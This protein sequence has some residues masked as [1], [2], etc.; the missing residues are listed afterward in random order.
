MKLPQTI[1]ELE[2]LLASPIT[3]PDNFN[4]DASSVLTR[5]SFPI[6]DIARA[7]T[8]NSLIRKIPTSHGS[9]KFSSQEQ[10]VEALNIL[11][12]IPLG[13][14][15]I[16]RARE[17]FP[18]NEQS[19]LKSIRA[20]YFEQLHS[21]PDLARRDSTF[22]L[23]DD[24]YSKGLP[25]PLFDATGKLKSGQYFEKF[26]PSLVESVMQAEELRGE[27][28]SQSSLLTTLLFELFK[29]TQ[30]H[31]LFDARNQGIVGSVRLISCRFYDL[32]DLVVPS[33]KDS[34]V[35]LEPHIAFVK[36]LQKTG[37]SMREQ[38]KKHYQGIL[39]FSVMD[40]GP[41]FVGSWLRRPVTVDEDISTEYQAVLSCLRAGHSTARNPNR[42]L[43]L[44][45]VLRALRKLNGFIRIRT[46]RISVYR[47]FNL[48]KD[49]MKD[50]VDAVLHD[51][52]KGL[53]S[54]ASVFGETT[55]AAVS[56][57]VP[58]EV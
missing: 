24:E 50:P 4:L 33:Q 6:E 17:W 32:N 53:S 7:Q 22:L 44:T 51:W 10:E 15:L 43:G 27:F 3:I 46:N 25:F 34:S 20:D 16:A 28:I 5:S 2:E 35:P 19:R 39:E 13:L 41:G 36:S 12:T 49:D 26:V 23:C 37:L 30:D 45:D 31:A 48:L 1:E 52:R 54:K 58:V 40:S 11:G 21:W 47:D 29:N 55:G 57:L 18:K 38:A 9:I 56:V 14:L 8:L 42:G